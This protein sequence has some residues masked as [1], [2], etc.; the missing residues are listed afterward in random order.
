MVSTTNLMCIVISMADSLLVPLILLLVIRKKYNT[1]IKAFL[2]GCGGFFLFAA[3]LESLMH[4]VIL[5]V[6][7]IGSTIQKNIYLYA[8]YGGLAAGIFE[9]TARFLIMKY[10]LK[11]E[12]DNPYNSIMYGAGHGG[13]E[14]FFLMGTGMLNNLIYASMINANQTDM[15][16]SVLPVEQQA[17]LQDI[18]DKL[19]S[20]QPYTFFIG[21]IER[22]PAVALH[23]ALSVLVW[24]AVT[25][26]KT[27]LF[28]LAI[29]IH[30]LVDGITVIVSDKIGKMDYGIAV[31]EGTVYVMSIITCI[32]AY[33]LWK[34]N[35]IGNTKK[36]EIM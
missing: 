25:K 30:A 17:Q 5:G 15:I 36:E 12:Y 33:K 23:I 34:S 32:V 13:F 21:Y 19:I 27:I 7:P 20:A 18:F 24:I 31:V 3:I 11:K 8:I 9:E 16:M 6:L 28:P 29:V 10:M 2:L 1:S 35:G 4:Q 26:G 22:I 14:V